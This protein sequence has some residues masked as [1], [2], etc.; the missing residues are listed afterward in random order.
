M[1]AGTIRLRG[2]AG[3]PPPPRTWEPTRCGSLSPTESGRSSRYRRRR[4]GGIRGRWPLEP[5]SSPAWRS[6]DRVLKR[7]SQARF[8]PQPVAKE[9]AHA[10]I[11]R[12]S[13]ACGGFIDLGPIACL[14]DPFKGRDRTP[15]RGKTLQ[16]VAEAPR[17]PGLADFVHFGTKS[18]ENAPARGRGPEGAGAWP[19]SSTSD[20]GRGAR[21]ART[22]AA[23]SAPG[24]ADFIRFG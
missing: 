17:E 14:L 16:R 11:A 2:S 1:R 20:P 10:P 23:P 5:V 3:L 19:I 4:A 13:G 7:G 22:A 8:W 12:A 6:R 18:R 9:R 24:S 15:S 21:L